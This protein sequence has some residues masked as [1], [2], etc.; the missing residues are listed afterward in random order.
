MGVTVRK[1]T[2]DE[3]AQLAKILLDLQGHVE[4][5]ER[6][7][8]SRSPPAGMCLAGA[9]LYARWTEWFAVDSAAWA[10]EVLGQL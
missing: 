4:G 7:Q 2:H 1:L 8:A 6:C 5:C 9:A 10:H 3:Q